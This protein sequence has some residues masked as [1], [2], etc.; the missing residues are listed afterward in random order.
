[1]RQPH[2]GRCVSG[3]RNEV[4]LH[5][6]SVVG[7]SHAGDWPETGTSKVKSWID[8]SGTNR[9]RR[10]M[11]ATLSGTKP[12][13]TEH[14]AHFNKTAHARS[15]DRRGAAMDRSPQPIRTGVATLRQALH[16]I[17]IP[18]RRR[19]PSGCSEHLPPQRGHPARSHRVEIGQF[20]AMI[21][22]RA[23]NPRPERHVREDHA[24]R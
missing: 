16:R 18:G 2:C 8:E 7:A 5:E 6:V 13:R 14:G 4:S 3:D 15:N 17:S 21:Q 11:L 24:Q 9:P 22:D 1:M 20:Q 23:E 12:S 10:W 19:C